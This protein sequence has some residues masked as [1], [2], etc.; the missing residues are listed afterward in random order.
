M[1]ASS[2][3]V[4]PQTALTAAI[5]LLL[6]F[7][8]AGNVLAQEVGDDYDD[9]PKS[10][11][12]T[13]S[14]AAASERARQRKAEAAAKANQQPELFPQATRKPPE[15]KNSQK[16]VKT[17]N[18][19][20]ALFDAG[21]YAE[22]LPKVD[23]YVATAQNPYLVSYLAQLAGNAAIK[24]EDMSKGADYYRKSVESNGLD[25]NGH[26]Q[27]MFNLAVTLSE[28]ER[29]PES[30]TWIDR[31]LTETK[32]ESEQAVGL[33]AFVLSRVGRAAEGAAL[34]EKLLAADPGNNNILL[35]AVSLYQEAENEEKA[36]ALLET[37]RKQG[38][39]KDANAYRMLFVSYLNASKYKEA[40][41]ALLDG[42]AKGVIAPSQTLAGDYSVLAQNYYAEEKVAQA[43]DF[44]TRAAKISTN[45]EAALNLAKVLVNEDRIT[46]AKA[47]AREALAKGIKRPQEAN[48]ILARPG[49]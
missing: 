42:V 7:A 41:E 36:L 10:T 11:T 9:K 38:N 19:L 3:R 28:L 35:N 27:I 43:I 46:E 34:Y 23:A 13:G 5:A 26:Y 39:L 12:A 16:D 18:E 48:N 47:A 21:K 1:T 49:K 2:A 37:A 32:N 17:A 25:N 33:K 15:K 20:Q 24:L 31:Y 14:A 29:Y 6:G 8:H 40:E 4:L 44:Y 45:G 30:L 22:L